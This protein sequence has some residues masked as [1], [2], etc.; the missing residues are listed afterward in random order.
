[1]SSN[2]LSV[3]PGQIQRYEAI[4]SS[5]GIIHDSKLDLFSRAN[6]S[7]SL[8]ERRLGLDDSKEIYSSFSM[9]YIIW[10]EIQILILKKGSD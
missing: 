7:L 3:P 6:S 5:T 1:M 8:L 10:Y 4:G 9:Y 2:W